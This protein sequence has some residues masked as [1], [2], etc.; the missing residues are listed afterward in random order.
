MLAS[1]E[2]PVYRKA[3]PAM[4]LRTRLAH[5]T[6]PAH[7]ALERELALDGTISLDRY[8]WYL[9]AMHAFVM[10]AEEVLRGDPRGRSG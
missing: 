1:S 8:A 7:E 4:D 10:P 2:N 6:R 5:A 9:R 3:L